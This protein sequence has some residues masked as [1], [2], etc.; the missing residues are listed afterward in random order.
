MDSRPVWRFGEMAR[1]RG[2]GSA[3]D[4]R[5][6]MS[7]RG[8]AAILAAAFLWGAGVAS[9][10]DSSGPSLDSFLHQVVQLDD[11]Q[12]AAVR[13]GEVVTK[14][15]PTA[16][17]PEIAAFGLVRA[18]GSLD[19]L[20]RLAMDVRS[21]R[22]NDHVLE[23]GIFSNPPGL[24]DLD[25]LHASSDDIEALEKCRPG[26]CD[27]KLGTSAIEEVSAIDWSLPDA[28]QRAIACVHRMILDFLIAYQR[29]GTDAMGGIMDKKAPKSRSEEYRTLHT[30]SPYLVEYVKEFNDYLVGYPRGVLPD[31]ENLFYWTQDD[32]GVK[33]VVS[34]YHMTIHRRPSGVF[35][36][37]KLLAAS[38]FFNASLEILVGVP[39]PD[40][41]GLYLLSLC[42]T[43]IDP[44]TGMLAGVLMG[45]VKGGLEGAVREN[46]GL[47][48]DLL[49]EGK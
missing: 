43:R 16:E 48:R 30:H 38:H 40:G 36:A 7:K 35:I 17:K 18:H 29:G 21:F 33:P 3:M 27:I 14:L 1:G 22:Q 2:D 41:D 9:G 6:S 42:R 31:T 8:S 24:E 23:M 20:F 49:D 47:A 39:A 12:L 32:F 13:K 25:G 34:L 19:D 46:L 5:S 37:N 44:P 45:K 4:R 15:L 11:E 28:E 26:D 10:S